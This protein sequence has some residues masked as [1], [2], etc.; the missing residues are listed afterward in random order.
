MIEI[1][2]TH[3]HLIDDAFAD[4]VDEV[5]LHAKEAGV[6]KMLLACCNSEEYR[7]IVDLSQRYKGIVY[8]SFGIHPENMEDDVEAQWM[9][10]KEAFEAS[11]AD[12]SGWRLSPVGEVGIDLHWDATRLSDQ[13]RLL[14]LEM[15][16]ACQHQLPLLLHIRDAMPQFLEF[17]RV[18]KEKYAGLRPCGILHCYSGTAAEALQALTMGDWLFGV[19]GTLT[20]KKSQVPEVVKA[21]GLERIVLETDAPYL[22][23]VPFRGKRNEPAYTLHTAQWLANWM[24]TDVEQV[25]QIT[26]SNAQKLLQ[27]D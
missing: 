24:E 10:L 1:I 19:G 20:Y 11:V 12:G 3:C 27:F 13:L 7:Q 2:D 25:A 4:D 26:T 22:A 16:Y 9:E 15:L 8:P 5:V 6:K 21:L 18:F 23:P 14:E 17:M